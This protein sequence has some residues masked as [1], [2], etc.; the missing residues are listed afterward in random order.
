MIGEDGGTIA[1]GL[2][3]PAAERYDL[4]CKLDRWV[5]ENVFDMLLVNP[6]FVEKTGMFSIN[7]SGPSLASADI[8][9][10]ITHRLSSGEI[11]T[12][13]LCFE[14]TETAAISNIN[15]ALN[16]INSLKHLGC[17]FSLDDFGSG[18]SSFGYLKTLP[19]DYLKID[20]MFVKNIVDE[21]IDLAMVKSI[22][23]VAH[24]MGM[25][26]IAEYV[27]ND[28]IRKLLVEIGVDFGQGYGIGKPVPLSEVLD[29]VR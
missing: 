9:S 1:P 26:S 11:N 27:E 15:T 6:H 20:G 3:L 23:D 19:V 22:N 17:K 25:Q 8:L 2:F 14:I 21:P 4:I 28:S 12:S 29:A 7:L 16:F 24:V 5:L 18:L 10:F 13:K